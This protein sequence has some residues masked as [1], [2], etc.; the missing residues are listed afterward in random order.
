MLTPRRPRQVR[1][2]RER[3]PRKEF[4]LRKGP[5]VII[6][7]IVVILVA[8]ALLIDFIADWLWFSEVGYVSVFI[9]KIVTQ[10]KFG[11]PTA[12]IL[13]VL[14]GLYLHGLKRGYFKRIISGEQTNVK[15]LNLYTNLL[16]LGFGAGSARCAA[17]GAMGFSRNLRHVLFDKVQKGISISR[18]EASRHRRHNLVEGR[19]RRKYPISVV[20]GKAYEEQTYIVHKAIDVKF[21]IQSILECICV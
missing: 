21:Y 17:V 10:L 16:S 19:Y 14:M 12:L 11:I 5:A 15:R 1:T 18:T 20:A 3:K 8:F 6:I 13:T 4:H 7:A 9:T 2:P